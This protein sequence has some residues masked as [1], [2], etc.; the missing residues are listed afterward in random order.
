MDERS[1]RDI[2]N[3]SMISDSWLSDEEDLMAELLE[4]NEKRRKRVKKG[5]AAVIAIALFINMFSIWPQV[6]NWTAFDFLQ[7]S[8]RLYQ[9]DALKERKQAVVSVVGKE[10]KGTGFVVDPSGVIITNYHVIENQKALYISLA[11]G[12]TVVPVVKEA[13]PTVDLA[14][15]KVE[16]TDLPHITPDYDFQWKEGEPVTFIGNPLGF[17]LIANEGRV[18]GT[19]RVNGISEPVMMLQAPVYQ[20][21][22]GSPVFNHE[23][24]VIGVIFATIVTSVAGNDQKIG[25]AIP[26]RT[27]KGQI[28]SFTP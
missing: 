24:K 26:I 25:L 18:I 20:G 14:I 9:D 22:S 11:G 7:V 17:S 12:K 15:L 28:Q 2:S 13:I 27:I 6:I 10:G 5:I 16:A 4:Q 8:Y 19:T 1:D 21:N 23:G 3:Q